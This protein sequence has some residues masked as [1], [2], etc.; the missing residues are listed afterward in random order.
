LPETKI[1]VIVGRK[2]SGKTTLVEK[3]LAELKAK[4]YRLGSLKHT[5]H[6]HQF[7]R[8][9]TDSFRHARAGAE[10]TLIVSPDNVVFFSASSE[11]RDLD[12]LMSLLFSHC[13]L[14]IGEGFKRSKLPKIEVLDTR[15]HDSP[16]CGPDDNLLAVV[17]EK[18]PGLGVPHFSGDQIHEIV[19]FV[20]ARFL[21][22]PGER[23]SP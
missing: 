22:E 3:L 21:A 19:E 18:D 5:G 1:L 14:I 16:I 7:D 6:S 11:N 10:S 8:E 20:E 15:K 2:K 4:G 17:S 23:G 9:G 13:D 12:H